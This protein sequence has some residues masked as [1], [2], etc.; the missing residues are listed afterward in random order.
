MKSTDMNAT[1]RLVTERVKAM[2]GT[3]S[4]GV[5]A[6]SFAMP[7]G[8]HPFAE[9]TQERGLASYLKVEPS[10]VQWVTIENPVIYNIYTNLRW[11]V[12]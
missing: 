12:E 8:I 4:S 11:R 1:A 2:A 6:N 7:S 9:R 10:V 3:L 5:F